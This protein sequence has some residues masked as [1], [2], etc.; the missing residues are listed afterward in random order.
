MPLSLAVLGLGD[1]AILDFSSLDE[2]ETMVELE[3]VREKVLV[4]G[5]R[6]VSLS[7]AEKEID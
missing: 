4:R 1:A 5:P 2:S 6:W 3:G 7:S